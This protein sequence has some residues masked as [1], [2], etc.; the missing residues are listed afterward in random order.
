MHFMRDD[1]AVKLVDTITDI[2][3]QHPDKRLIV[4]DANG[5]PQKQ[6]ADIEN[7]VVQGVDA[8]IVV[9]IDEKRRSKALR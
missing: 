6:L 2:V 7:L 5:A 4:T 1:Y 3:E 8:I 9:P